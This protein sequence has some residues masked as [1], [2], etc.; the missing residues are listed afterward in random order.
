MAAAQTDQL[1]ELML[2]AGD[3]D[4]AA[5]RLFYDRTS[6]SILAFLMRMLKDR[7]HA[8]DVLQ[9]SMV[10]AWNKAGEFDPSLAAAKTWITTIARRRALDVIRSHG[11]RQE[12]IDQ[13]AA[14]I[15]TVLG[16]EESAKTEAES[17]A[18]ASRIVYCFSQLNADAAACI[19]FA[20]IEGLTMREV[21][22]RIDKS[23]GTVKSWIRRGLQKLKACMQP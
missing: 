7:Y 17:N 20:Y 21:A 5:F 3:G 8:E 9:E 2:R 4:E 19:Q 14:D 16:H 12:I 18:T 6:P 10:I 13:G 11:R 23:L 1:D 15:R 22:Q